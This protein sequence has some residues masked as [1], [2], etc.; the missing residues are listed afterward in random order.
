MAKTKKKKTSKQPQEL[1]SIYFLKILLYVIIGAQWIHLTDNLGNSIVPI[2]VGLFVGILFASHE[3]FQMDRKIEYALLLV[4][5]LVGFWSQ[6]GIYIT[7]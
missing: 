3:H 1:D 4:A 6:A 5:A 7:I 2:P